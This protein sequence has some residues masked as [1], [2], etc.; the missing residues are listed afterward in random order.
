M[1]AAARAG[2]E[3]L[4]FPGARVRCSA[5]W[6]DESLVHGVVGHSLQ[7]SVK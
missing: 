3:A 2:D 5:G 6:I 7:M 1:L 4:G